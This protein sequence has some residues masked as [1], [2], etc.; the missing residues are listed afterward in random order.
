MIKALFLIFSPGA[1]WD[2]IVESRRSV[3]FILMIYVVPLV[4][5]SCAAEAFGLVH[6]GKWQVAV[7]RLKHFSTGE[8]IIFEL[9]Q[10]LLWLGI[11][12]LGSQLLKALGETFHGRHTFAQTFTTVGYSLGP[13]L[14]LHALD[15]LRDLSPWVPWL[16]GILLSIG[17]LYHGVPRAMDPDPPQAF[18]LF[19]MSSLLLFLITGLARFFTAWYLQ[20][21]FA[22]IEPVVSDLGARLSALLGLPHP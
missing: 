1:T 13:L 12:F 17:V 21:R 9:F 20:G 19:M 14:L 15:A 6:W 18:G 7:S 8:A 10:F 2:R 16:V 22:K 11:V 3:G 4:V 5:L